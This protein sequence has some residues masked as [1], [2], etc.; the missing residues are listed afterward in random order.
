MQATKRVIVITWSQ[1]LLVLSPLEACVL[2]D[3]QNELR[4]QKVM[5]LAQVRGCSEFHLKFADTFSAACVCV[6][7]LNVCAIKLGRLRTFEFFK[8]IF[9]TFILRAHLL[10]WTPQW[11]NN[12]LLFFS[13]V[14]WESTI[15]N[16]LYLWAE[17]N[18]HLVSDTVILF[19]RQGG[20]AARQTSAET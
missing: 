5:W 17:R 20:R 18:T 8:W 14:I 19:M 4:S 3:S 10:L 1:H 7:K 12:C 16:G 13:C 6:G 9:I 2:G 15:C 11:T